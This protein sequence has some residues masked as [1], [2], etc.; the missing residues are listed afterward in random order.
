M[1]ANP[2]IA[3]RSQ[4]WKPEGQVSGTLEQFETVHFPWKESQK[5]ASKP[6]Q[7]S[8]VVQV[9][10]Q[11]VAALQVPASQI[12][13]AGQSSLT[14]HPPLEPVVELAVVL[15]VVELVV[16]LSVVELSVSSPESP[17]SPLAP[18]APPAP[19]VLPAPL[20]PAPPLP[21]VLL[22]LPLVLVLVLLLVLVST[23]SSHSSSGVGFM[24]PSL[25]T[26]ASP[27]R[28]SFSPQ[29]MQPV[30]L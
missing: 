10:P 30:G 14:V 17:P 22:V 24:K 25:H 23:T 9:C 5:F 8:L 15:S 4:H 3:V 21:V 12:C 28:N 18:A 6:A 11:P 29:V 13:S 19:V 16:E 7:S 2:G 26:H 1:T 27:C 20:P